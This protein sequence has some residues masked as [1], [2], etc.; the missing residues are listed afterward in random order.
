MPDDVR[1][2]DKNDNQR[3]A[4]RDQQISLILRDF[5]RPLCRALAARD[6]FKRLDTAPVGTTSFCIRIRSVIVR[7]TAVV[8]AFILAQARE[9]Q[10]LLPGFSPG[11]AQDIGLKPGL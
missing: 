9:H 1:D 7:T 11:V 6:N 5:F 8:L 4:H 2:N 10:A 3:R